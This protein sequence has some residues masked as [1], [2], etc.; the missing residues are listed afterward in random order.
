MSVDV[1]TILTELQADLAERLRADEMFTDIPVLD[2]RKGDLLDGIN[3]ALGTLT[4]VGGKMGACVVVL[5]PTG[6]DDMPDAPSGP[7]SLSISV[8]VLEDVLVNGGASGTGKEALTIARRVHRALKHYAPVGLCNALVPQK[9]CLLPVDNPLAPVAYEVRFRTT[10]ARTA[11]LKCGMPSIAAA[12]EA[13][14]K[15]ITLTSATAGAAIYYT[16]DGTHPRSGNTAA[17][18]YAGPFALAATGTVRAAAFKTGYL[19][20][21]VNMAVI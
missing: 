19:G 18:L 10:E 3:Q 15:T 8:L 11:A 7:L 17:T 21:D 5:S 13:F 9:P 4:A 16:T 20:S 12:G 2:E 14:P 1:D 6:N